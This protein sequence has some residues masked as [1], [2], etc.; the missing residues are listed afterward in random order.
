MDGGTVVFVWPMLRRALI[1]AAVTSTLLSCGVRREA[2]HAAG[3]IVIISI[4][5]L[6]ADHLRIYGGTRAV[7][8]HIE[9][10]A[11]DAI[12]FESAY[13]HVPL[14]LPS[15]VTMLTGLL[16]AEAGVRNNLGYRFDS[17]RHPTIPALLK[18]KGYETGAA[19][20]AYVLRSATGLGSLFDHYDDEMDRAPAGGAI[21]DVQRRGEATVRSALNWI[22]ARTGK[23]YF[24]LLHLFE[25]HAPYAPP[26]PLRSQ[27]ADAPYDGE[28]AAVDAHVGTLLAA[29]KANGDYERATII[30]LSDH[31]EGLGDHG[32][33]QHGIFLYREAIHVPLIVK[34]PAGEMR[35]TRVKAPVQL[36]D[37]MPTVAAIAGF[38]SPANLK[39]NS[40]VSI[41]RGDAPADRRI[42]SETMYPRI[43]LGW[44]DLGS[45][46]DSKH[47]FIDAPVPELY[48]LVNDR[49]ETAN[50][51]T[52]N[53]RVYASMRSEM[54][55]YDRSLAPPQVVDPEEAAKLTALGYLGSTNAA[56]TLDGLPDPKDGIRDLERVAA[57]GV[58]I[59][60]GEF[61]EAAAVLQNIVKINPSYA[62]A[63]T[64]LARALAGLGRIDEATAAYRKTIELAPMLAPGTAM[65]L[66]ELFMRQGRFDDAIEHAEIAIATHPSAARLLIAQ[67][68][69]GRRDFA[70]AERE[71]SLLAHDAETRQEAA[72]IVAQVRNA[73][74][75][76]QDA[77]AILDQLQ[78]SLA[79]ESAPP[80]FWFARGDALV[81][82]N[83][84]EEAERAFD[85]EVRRYPRNREAYVRAAVLQVLSG[86]EADGERTL[87]AMVR[88]NPD[89]SSRALATETLRALRR[90]RSHVAQ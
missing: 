27:Y 76:P 41:A 57:A 79:G 73:E 12:V 10:L 11:A 18:A 17:T 64:I 62:D 31:G 53:R 35:G 82:M 45:L 84:V 51:L 40:L 7:T 2:A 6:R 9:S 50:V 13:S 87:D 83:R 37:L 28:I 30:L 65:S 59:E 77:L 86:R 42:F 38:E 25:P 68:H 71:S 70:S 52:A 49:A 89:S 75:R 69:L 20:S 58:M 74:R 63:W 39:G 24:F 47:H 8:P 85:E 23:P 55:N 54:Q 15:H 66:A 19:V 29:L 88:A 32:E 80:N 14:T 22:R 60:R 48:D 43:H 90:Q 81:R 34:L 72:I 61:A 4:D 36:I 78:R 3:P 56:A 67:A 33:A 16:P 26:E 46:I 5:T 1:A 21:G 44:S